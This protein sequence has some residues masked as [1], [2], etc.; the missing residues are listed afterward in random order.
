MSP[1]QPV[2]VLFMAHGA[3]EDPADLAAFYAHI[4]HGR[5]P[6]PAVLEELRRRYAAI[7]GRSPLP[8]L[9]QRLG[10]RVAAALEAR[11]PGG[12][13]L[14]VGFLHTPPF[15]AQAA[16]SLAGLPLVVGLALAPHYNRFAYEEG[17]R[18]AAEA[19]LAGT[20][21]RLHLI[22]GWGGDPG[23]VRWLADALRPLWAAAPSGSR[24]YFSAH[25]LPAR[26]LAAGDPYPQQLAEGAAAVA[27]AA[28]LP[29]GSWDICYQSRGRTGE[30]WAGPDVLEILEQ[31]A[32]RGTPQVILCPHGFVAD[33]LEVLYDLDIEAHGRARALGLELVRTPMP[34]DDPA[35]AGALADLVAATAAV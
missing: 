22:P 4:R 1:V 15:I 19:A 31:E 21:S 9:T 26:Y 10:E 25:S 7:G 12:Y 29:A 2:G 14:A 6:V 30:P 32:G 23:Y 16:E 27:A 18:P 5:P 35:F 20:G 3:A 28:G 8:A 34:N 24:V 33:H 13:R 11:S 17:Y